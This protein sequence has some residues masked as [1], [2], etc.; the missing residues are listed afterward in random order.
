MSVDP[1][2]VDR[3]AGLAWPSGRD[4]N[5]PENA[6]QRPIYFVHVSR[7]ACRP[8]HGVSGGCGLET[9]GRC[10]TTQ[11]QPD[12]DLT[13]RMLLV[14]RMPAGVLC[15]CWAISS[16]VIVDLLL[17]LFRIRDQYTRQALLLHLDR[18]N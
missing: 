10:S 13:T 11:V 7:I 12:E 3:A 8:P 15:A 6:H 16:F 5:G 4:Q 9:P 2:P 1:H 18:L 17:E 14:A